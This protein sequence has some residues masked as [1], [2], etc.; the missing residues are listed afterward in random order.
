MYHFIEVSCLSVNG[1]QDKQT[2]NIPGTFKY[3][4]IRVDS[5]DS[6][7]P[8]SMKIN[9]NQVVVTLIGRRTGGNPFISNET[10]AQIMEKRYHV[11]GHSDA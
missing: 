7:E 5:I 4:F 2:L 8:A 11:L 3:V 10:P 1:E 6:L 9:N